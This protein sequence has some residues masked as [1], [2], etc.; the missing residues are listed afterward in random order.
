MIQRSFN[1]IL[2]KRAEVLQKEDSDLFIFEIRE[3]IVEEAIKI[4]YEHYMERQ[5][6]FFT[7]HC[8]AQAWLK[9][10]DW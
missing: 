10:I 7:V 6:A 1:R 4:G 3:D 8:A 2:Y 5:N 9:L